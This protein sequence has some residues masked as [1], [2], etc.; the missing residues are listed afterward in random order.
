[1]LI[2]KTYFQGDITIPNLQEIQHDNDL[3]Q[4]LI[5]SKSNSL[6]E[7]IL[8]RE[9]YLALKS[10]LDVNG[11]LKPDADQK[12]KDL[13]NGQSYTDNDQKFYFKGLIQ[14]GDLYKTSMIADFVF[15]EWLKQTRSQ[16]T[17][18]GEVVV[19]AQNATN[20]NSNS[21]FV[22]IW[23]RFIQEFGARHHNHVRRYCIKGVPFYDYFNGGNSN[24]VSLV[25]FLTHFSDVYEDCPLELPSYVEN[26]G[27]INSLG[28]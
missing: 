24:N 9:N 17:G 20:V 13:V 2:D 10:Q 8:G 22:S 15:C 25:Q 4:I 6:L 7:S 1:M 19:N 11:K 14:E 12:W 3:V 27:I 21:K 16:Q 26:Y 23:N 18:V 5:E 28:I